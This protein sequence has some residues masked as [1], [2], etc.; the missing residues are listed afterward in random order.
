MPLSPDPRPALRGLVLLL[1]LT[2][3]AA[4]GGDHTPDAAS[5][6]AKRVRTQPASALFE[7]RQVTAPAQV[8]APNESALSS[9]VSARVARIHA[10]VGAR[11]AAGQLLLQLDDT[12]YRLALNQARA[13][14]AASQAREALAEQRLQ[15]ARA[16]LERQFVSV[17]DVGALESELEAARAEVA[18]ARADRD[19]AARN[20]DKCAVTAPFD[21]V[22][23]ER[24][25]QVGVLAPAGTALLQLVD[26]APPEVE[27]TLQGPDSG[28]LDRAANLRFDSQGRSYPVELLRLAPVLDRGART[29]VAR[30]R[31]TAE[32]PDAGSTGQVRWAEPDRQLPARLQVLR[33]GTPGVF[34]VQEGIAV[35]VEA[36]GASPGRPFGIDLP[37]EASVVI[38]G[39]QAL[40]DGDRVTEA[41][42]PAPATGTDDADDRVRGDGLA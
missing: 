36:P 8:I 32:P 19:V 3:L 28:S 16:L 12:D 42:K 22:V 17:D 33:D 25:A 39:H 41:D 26:T 34:I 15:R 9:D 38:E 23:V 18:I 5:D 35:F 6:D 20:V 11:V 13:R 30:F 2:A 40:Q 10:D 29:R 4:C 27:A 31:F 24:F 1:V 14:V 7:A 37:P 21:G